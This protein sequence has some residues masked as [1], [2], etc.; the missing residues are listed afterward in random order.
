MVFIVC[1]I[2]SIIFILP[3]FLLFLAAF[4]ITDMFMVSYEIH[5]YSQSLKVLCDLPVVILNADECL[6]CREMS[7]IQSLLFALLFY[8]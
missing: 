6:W 4:V 2:L 3:Y 1:S 5:N 8:L 7:L